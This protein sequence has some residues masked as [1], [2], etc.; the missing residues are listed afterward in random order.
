MLSYD[1]N[2]FNHLFTRPASLVDRL[3]ADLETRPRFEASGPRV[4]IV[5]TE[6]GFELT[7]E[8]PGFTADDL[9]IT[10]HEGV[11]SVAGK[12]EPGDATPRPA[13]PGRVL[14]R[15]R[16][17]ASFVRRFRLGDQVDP[18]GIDA[19]VRDGLLTLKLP[20]PATVQP[21]KIS[22]RGEAS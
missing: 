9:D 21:R 5:E 15:E 4:D 22:V 18:E 14:V 13:S 3:F 7:A 2:G 12:V 20:K 19:R 17:T 16:R 6:D 10:M 8:V 11:L 1:T